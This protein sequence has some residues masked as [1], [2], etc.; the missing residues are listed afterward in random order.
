MNGARDELIE[1]LRLAFSGELAAAYAYRGHWHSVSDPATRQRI[2][3]I[4][5]EELYHRQ[6]V[7]Q[8]LEKLES[9]PGRFK[10][11]K[12]RVIGRTLGLLCHVSGWLIPMY[13]AGKLESG[14][15]VEYEK[16]ARFAALSGHYEFVQC[17]LSMAEV[18]WEHEKYFRD[19]VES[20]R[21]A[22]IIPIWPQP[23]PKESIRSS[24]LS[25]F[26]ATPVGAGKDQTE[27]AF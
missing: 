20:H 1:I 12:A 24:F 25:E 4:E 23:Q 10:E 14:N 16:A 27:F 8:M 5:L 22:G 2:N 26:G 13:G 18:E 15:I 3:E 17:L 6:L 11:L 19:C 21:L 9:R 7:G